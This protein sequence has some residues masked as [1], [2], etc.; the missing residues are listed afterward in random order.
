[1][2]NILQLFEGTAEP[3]Y[4]YITFDRF[5]A[6]VELNLIPLAYIFSLLI[7]TIRS[8]VTKVYKS[9]FALDGR[10]SRSTTKQP[11]KIEPK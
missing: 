1:M 10:V 3:A 5:S 7:R 2:Q 11:N 4:S 8:L 9:T 6:R